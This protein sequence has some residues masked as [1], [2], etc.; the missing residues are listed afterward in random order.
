[1]SREERYEQ[2]RTEVYQTDHYIFHYKAG[3]LAEKNLER[4]AGV[5][6]KAFAKICGALNVTYPEHIHYYFSDSPQE[7]GDVIFDGTP[8]NGVAICGENKIYAVY[9]EEIMCIGPH[10]DALHRY[11]QPLHIVCQEFLKKQEKPSLLH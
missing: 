8:C 2:E 1:M 9:N 6:E 3:S 5:Q 7:V 4:I 11:I 10:E